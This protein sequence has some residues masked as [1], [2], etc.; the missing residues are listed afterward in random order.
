MVAGNWKMNGT[1][2]SLDEIISI[3]D[4]SNTATCDVVLCPPST[5]LSEAIKI[6]NDSS[7][8]IGAQNCHHNISGAHTGE[9]SAKML[10]NL[11][12]ETVILGHSERRADNL[13][14]NALVKEKANTSHKCNLKTII[15]VG[16]SE[17]ERINGKT[18][19]IITEQLTESLPLS[20]TIN[21]TI[22]AYEPRW[23]IGT[24]KTPNNNEIL[25]VHEILRNQITELRSKSVASAMRIIY[26]GSVNPKN[27]SEIFGINGVDGALVGGASLSA[28][29]L[30]DIINSA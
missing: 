4:L 19:K 18:T 30:K 2:Q 27:C 24:G 28:A 21:N 23:A 5:L 12:V 11:G 25:E 29:N 20:A 3:R 6:A 7:L 10:I 26:G 9:I 22:I 15:C 13:E 1:L 17:D 16:E 14:T 8:K